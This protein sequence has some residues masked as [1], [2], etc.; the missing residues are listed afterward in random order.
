MPRAQ[1]GSATATHRPE[2][3]RN[4]DTVA[5]G[6]VFGIG[7]VEEIAIALDRRGVAPYI[8]EN[9]DEANAYLREFDVHH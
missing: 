7:F 5:T 8:Y 4:E 6:G 2:L 1:V 9:S 3:I